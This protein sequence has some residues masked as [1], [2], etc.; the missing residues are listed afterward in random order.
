MSTDPPKLEK[1]IIEGKIY[2]TPTRRLG[3][4]THVSNY[5]KSV[6]QIVR[7]ENAALIANRLVQSVE[8]SSD[9]SELMNTFTFKK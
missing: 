9:K 5:V 8:E 2:P 3:K 6:L 4:I 7:A 1:L